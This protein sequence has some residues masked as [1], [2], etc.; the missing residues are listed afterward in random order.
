MWGYIKLTILREKYYKL[1]RICAVFIIGPLLIYKGNEHDDK[2]LITIGV[3][4][5]LWDGLK[6]K[7][8]ESSIV[9]R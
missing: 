3:L 6:L 1:G 5:I 9:I 8:D 4:L 7:M 2:L